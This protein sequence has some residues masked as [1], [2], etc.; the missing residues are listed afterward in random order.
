[1]TQAQTQAIVKAKPRVVEAKPI[2]RPA[3]QEE[4]RCAWCHGPAPDDRCLV[5]FFGLFYIR[6][7]FLC[8]GIL[9]R[10]ASIFADHFGQAQK[11]GVQQ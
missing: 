4:L 3:Q 2:R 6:L 10:T 5:S 1:M 8:S 9:Y 7:C 11:K